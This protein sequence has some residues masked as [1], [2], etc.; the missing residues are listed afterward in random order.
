[1]MGLQVEDR[2]TESRTE[3]M[4][5]ENRIVFPLSISTVIDFVVVTPRPE[6]DQQ[7]LDPL[8]SKFLLEKVKGP[9]ANEF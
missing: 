5:D 6:P 7:H 3:L 2:R 1:M 9:T 8:C 4:P